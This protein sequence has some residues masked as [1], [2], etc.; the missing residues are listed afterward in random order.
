MRKIVDFRA[1]D[2]IFRRVC[3]PYSAGTPFCYVFIKIFLYRMDRIGYNIRDKLEETRA[4]DLE[5]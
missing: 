4:R 3:L 1:S 5:Y 2:D